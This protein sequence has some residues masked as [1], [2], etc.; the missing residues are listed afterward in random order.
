[1]RA[2]PEIFSEGKGG[3][4]NNQKYITVRENAP[5]HKSKEALRYLEKHNFK[6]LQI[7]HPGPGDVAASEIMPPADPR[8]NPC[9]AFRTPFFGNDGAS[10]NRR[11]RRALKDMRWY[12]E[13]DVFFNVGKCFTHSAAQ[14]ELV[15]ETKRL[16]PP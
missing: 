4:V 15:C 16:P 8:T 13:N 3:T 5:A 10:E 1:V 12:L 14:R 2:S 9:S 11:A 7:G 6:L